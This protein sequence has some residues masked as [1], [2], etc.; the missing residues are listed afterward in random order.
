MKC[1]ICGDETSDNSIWC[2]GCLN[3]VGCQL[4]PDCGQEFK[5]IYHLEVHMKMYCKGNQQVSRR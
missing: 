5:N 1:K 3:I 2:K 4:C